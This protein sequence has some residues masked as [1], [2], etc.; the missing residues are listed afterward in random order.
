MPA[1]EQDLAARHP[2]PATRADTRVAVAVA[3]ICRLCG[4][5]ALAPVWNFGETPLANAYL[6]AAQI[7]E[8]EFSAPLEVARCQACHLLQLRHAVSPD[9]LFRDYLYVS[10][11]SPRFIAHFAAYA[12]RLVERFHLGEQSLVADIGSND[13]ILLK[14]LQARG[15]RVLGVEPAQRIAAGA[16]AAGIPTVA[17]FFTPSLAARL[18]AEHGPASVITANNVFAHTPDLHGFVDAVRAWLKDDG[19]YVFE[20]QYLGDLL[21]KNL[22]DIVYHEHLCYYHATPLVSYFAARGLA[23][24][25]IERV[26]AHGGSLRV[27]VQ[28]AGGPHARAD[29]LGALLAEEDRAGLNRADPYH[30]FAVRIARNKA[31]LNRLLSGLR[32]A[33]KRVVGYGAPAKATTLCYAFGLGAETLAYIVDDDRVFKQGRF[34]PGTHIPIVPADRLYQDHPDY[35]LILAWNFAEPIREQHRRFTEQGGRFIV[36]VPEPRVV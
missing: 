24:F 23:V 11:T 33:G 35:C 26:P 1:P 14:P 3:T 5:S 21:E 32:R 8:P 10:S 13:G 36:P 2:T 28:R 7:G 9:I 4:S 30:A 16:N 22:F 18:R 17:E 15:V 12:D 31:A 25:D 29:R 27:F 19:I 20:V 34:M 6:T